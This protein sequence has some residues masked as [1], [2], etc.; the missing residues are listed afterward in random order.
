MR[1]LTIYRDDKDRFD[2]VVV[3]SIGRT[4]GTDFSD[5]GSDFCALKFRYHFGGD[6]TIVRLSD[7]CMA[8]HITGMGLASQQIAWVMQER[9]GEP[10]HMIDTDYSFDI[11]L[12]KCNNVGDIRD[13]MRTESGG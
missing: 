13:R 3:A 6:Q 12:W 7:D 8:V 10:L 9:L 1:N 11:E 5:D 4:E 2:R